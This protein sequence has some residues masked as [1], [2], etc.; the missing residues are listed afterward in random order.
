MTTPD[1][2]ASPPPSRPAQGRRPGFFDFSHPIYR[3]LWVRLAVVGGSLG[4]AAVEAVNGN[5]GWALLFGG[6]GLAALWGLFITYDPGAGLTD[7]DRPDR[8][9][10]KDTP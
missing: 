4:W 8:P 7:P 6:A 10:R 3:P 5:P 1:P 2:K 9:D